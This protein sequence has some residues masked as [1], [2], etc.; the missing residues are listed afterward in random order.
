MK[1]PNSKARSS[2]KFVKKLNK[3]DKTDEKLTNHESQ[4]GRDTSVDDK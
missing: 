1:P 2:L 3:V 4:A